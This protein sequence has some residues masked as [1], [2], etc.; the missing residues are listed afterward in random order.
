MFVEMLCQELYITNYQDFLR[1]KD[2]ARGELSVCS[3][4]E[5]AF[6]EE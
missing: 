5:K 6:Y 2:K 1:I 4:S 3:L